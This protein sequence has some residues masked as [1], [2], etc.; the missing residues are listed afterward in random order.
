M[1]ERLYEKLE[2]TTGTEG[3]MKMDSPPLKYERRALKDLYSAIDAF[4][5]LIHEASEK[6]KRQVS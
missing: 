1:E 5:T 3:S 2:S 6:V 4:E